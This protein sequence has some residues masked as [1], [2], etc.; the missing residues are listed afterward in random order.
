MN[1]PGTSSKYNKI[2]NNNF[3]YRKLLDTILSA[4]T[5]VL[6]LKVLKLLFIKKSYGINKTN[7]LTFQIQNGSRFDSETFYLNKI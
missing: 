6:Y 1:F 5:Y 3:V 7:Y 2:N 4:C